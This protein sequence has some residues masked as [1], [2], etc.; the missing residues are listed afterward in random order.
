MLQLYLMSPS[1][2]HFIKKTLYM[3]IA[4]KFAKEEQDY[5]VKN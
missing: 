4:L 1:I 3:N 2:R 5:S